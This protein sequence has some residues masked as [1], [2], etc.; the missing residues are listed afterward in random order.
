MLSVM[1]I[2]QTWFDQMGAVFI[3]WQTWYIVVCSVICV[4]QLC[5]VFYYHLKI[6][7]LFTVQSHLI[8]TY[9]KL[10]WL[11][12]TKRDQLLRPRC[13]TRRRGPASF[14]WSTR[15]PKAESL[16]CQ[17]NWT[18]EWNT[19]IKNKHHVKKNVHVCV[20]SLWLKF[21]FHLEDTH[22]FLQQCVGLSNP[23]CL[24]LL[25]EKIYITLFDEFMILNYVW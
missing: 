14:C 4:E 18:I 21:K 7:V 17:A 19:N 5:Q 24:S 13:S 22:N 9:A 1:C 23:C 11:M 16:W 3:Q 12:V 20:C 8:M 2:E 15:E 6:I 25:W 10:S